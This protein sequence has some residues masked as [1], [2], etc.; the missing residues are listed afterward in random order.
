MNMLRCLSGLALVLAIVAPARAA[1][2]FAAH[3]DD[4]VLLMGRNA[5][6]DIRANRP[7][8]LVVLTAGDAGNGNA[9]V[10]LAGLGGRYYNQMGNPYYRVRHNAHEAALATWV[11]AAHSRI[12]QRSVEY[13]GPAMSAVEKVRLGNVVLYNLNLPDGQLH[14]FVAGAG[15]PLTDVNGANRY[16]PATLYHT[17]RQIVARHSKDSAA[18]V[19]HIPEHTPGF[20]TPGYNDFGQVARYADHLDHTAT[21]RLVRAALAPNAALNCL[22]R[23]VYMG[24]AVSMLP[25]VMSGAEKASQDDAYSALNTVLKNQGNVTFD[26]NRRAMLLGSMDTFHT[27][28]YGKQNTREDTVSPECGLAATPPMEVARHARLQYQGGKSAA[29]VQLR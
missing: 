25:E 21:G 17:L 19:V 22:R 16:L 20:S 29:R 6:L 2:Y 11:P 8:V 18:P 24:Y 14:R 13:F 12:A 27:S 9:A 3:Q 1:V 26:A 5:Q 7:T 15:A 4:I 28:F 10:A 23:V